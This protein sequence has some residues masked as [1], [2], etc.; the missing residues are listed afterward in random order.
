MVGTFEIPELT[1]NNRHKPAR[2]AIGIAPDAVG[3]N[4]VVAK[5]LPG[6]D[7]DGDAV[8]VIPNKSGRIKTSPALVGLKNFDPQAAFPKYEGMKVMT[9]QQKA[10]Q[11]G[12]VSNLINDMTIQKRIPL[13]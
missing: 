5:R 1:V 4:S 9:P 13:T 6:A 3:I 8:M 12:L 10:T 7:F 2:E 11:M